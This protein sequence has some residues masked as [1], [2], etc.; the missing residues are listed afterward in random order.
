M[1]RHLGKRAANFPCNLR[2]APG[3]EALAEAIKK[4]FRLGL[5]KI[6][7]G[8]YLCNKTNT[9]GGAKNEKQ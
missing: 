9:L 7:I 3:F 5:D 6:T 4:N 1:S 8:W 2:V